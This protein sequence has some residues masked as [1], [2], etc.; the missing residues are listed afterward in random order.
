MP[1]HDFLATTLV[2][3]NRFFHEFSFFRKCSRLLCL[4]MTL[5]SE[6]PLFVMH[7]MM[8]ESLNK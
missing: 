7:G 2:D 6:L 1:S 8:S 4:Q 5:P 3:Y